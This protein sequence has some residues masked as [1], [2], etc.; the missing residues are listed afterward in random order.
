[1]PINWSLY[2]ILY[3]GYQEVIGSDGVQLQ[4]APLHPSFL[5]RHIPFCSEGG[6]VALCV[7]ISIAAGAPPG[8]LGELN[9]GT[10]GP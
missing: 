1:M 9:G 5:R 8:E 3:S 2:S 4:R 7:G 10:E 6:L